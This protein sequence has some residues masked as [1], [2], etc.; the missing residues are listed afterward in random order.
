MVRLA[1][2]RP[3]RG[4]VLRE[5][6]RAP[7]WVASPRVREALVFNPYTPARLSIGLTPL[8]NTSSLRQV[9]LDGNLHPAVQRFAR[10]ILHVR[11]PEPRTDPA[12]LAIHR[13]SEDLLDM[14]G[15]DLPPTPPQEDSVDQV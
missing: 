12:V 4:L 8:L 6:G 2:Y 10:S 11:R 5:I 3:N 7:K 14:L 1:A 15:I 9:G 13:S